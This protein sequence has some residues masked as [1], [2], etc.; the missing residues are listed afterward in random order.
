M[1]INLYSFYLRKNDYFIDLKDLK[2][3]ENILQKYNYDNESSFLTEYKDTKNFFCIKIKYGRTKPYSETVDNLKENKIE[4]N[5]KHKNQVELQKQ[6]FAFFYYKKNIIFFS[7]LKEINK[8]DYILKK[9][10]NEY[11]IK[12]NIINIDDIKKYCNKINKI[13]LTINNNLLGQSNNFYPILN[14]ETDKIGLGQATQYQLKIKFNSVSITDNFIEFLKN[15]IN[16]KDFLE[17]LECIGH[18]SEKNMDLIFN[19][20][21]FVNKINIDI[22]KDDNGFYTFETLISKVEYYLQEN[23]K[24][25]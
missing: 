24:K 19:T 4:P 25:I 11:E 14:Q 1:G 3:K 15:T 7:S 18:N 16:K 20:E 10:N 6:F 22:D 9:I 21:T 23:E 13:K 12:K 2:L 17:S 8:L 5:P